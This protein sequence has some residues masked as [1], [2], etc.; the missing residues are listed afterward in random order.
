MAAVVDLE[1]KALC[2]LQIIARVKDHANVKILQAG[3]LPSWR[4]LVAGPERM[5]IQ[6]PEEASTGQVPNSRA[7]GGQHSVNSVIYG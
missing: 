2:Q 1:L 5:R 3:N 6:W 4:T 7:Q